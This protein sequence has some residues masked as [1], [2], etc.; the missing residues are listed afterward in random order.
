MSLEHRHEALLPGR[1]FLSRQLIYV[2]GSGILISLWLGIGVL[3]YHAIGRLDWVDAVLNASFI[4]AGMGP[5]DPMRTV[6]GK[7][8]A[9]VYAIFSGIAFLST[10][11][12]LMT[13]LV[14]R[15]LHQFHLEDGAKG[16]GSHKEGNQLR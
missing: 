11:G 9:S 3:G 16:R 8:F 5:A 2:A 12:I 14:H 13:P 1:Q 15:F 4:L 7:L 10:I 6:G